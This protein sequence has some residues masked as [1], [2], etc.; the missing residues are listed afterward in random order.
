MEIER[1]FL[2][3]NND[4]MTGIDGVPYHQGYLSDHPSRTVRVRVAGDI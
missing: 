3:L 4:F 2:V 1:K